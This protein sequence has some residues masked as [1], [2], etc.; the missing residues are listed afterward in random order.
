M[1]PYNKKETLESLDKELNETRQQKLEYLNFINKLDKREKELSDRRRDM[2]LKQY[3]NM[4]VRNRLIDEGEKRGFSKL[5][6]D[7]LR[8]CND[9]W[10]QDEVDNEIIDTFILLENFIKDVE[11]KRNKKNK[12]GLFYILGDLA[13]PYGKGGENND[14]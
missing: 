11:N 2:G 1:K 13:Y 10:N 6:I 9:N 14:N 7:S 4:T 12:K 3:S 5:K 8:E